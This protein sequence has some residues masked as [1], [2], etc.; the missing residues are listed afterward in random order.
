V[1]GI[2]KILH[3]GRT[4]AFPSA[5]S[6]SLRFLDESSRAGLSLVY[7]A[8]LQ[9]R[10]YCGSFQPAEN[11]RPPVVCIVYY[12]CPSGLSGVCVVEIP[13]YLRKKIV[14]SCELVRPPLSWDEGEVNEENLA[15]ILSRNRVE[16]KN[17]HRLGTVDTTSRLEFNLFIETCCRPGSF[18][19]YPAV[20]AGFIPLPCR[21]DPTAGVSNPPDRYCSWSA[22]RC[23]LTLSMRKPSMLSTMNE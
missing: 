15:V 8:S 7:P 19:V 21:T 23:T 11:H 6:Q 2:K 12:Y 9:D 5:D 16:A 13:E 18:L 20:C 10:S 4:A 14:Y 22:S 3:P 17:P 1:G